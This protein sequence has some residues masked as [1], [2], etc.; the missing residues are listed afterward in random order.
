GRQPVPAAADDHDVVAG[1]RVGMAPQP[2]G[3]L[4]EMWADGTHRAKGSAGEFR[5][6][7]TLARAVRAS[8]LTRDTFGRTRHRDP[9]DAFQQR[10]R[11]DDG[12]T[13]TM[14]RPTREGG[15]TTPTLSV[16]SLWK[17]FGP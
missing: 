10:K 8:T 7:A 14:E 11:G 16:R 1:L 3:V 13:A 6:V 15:P 9:T 17:V 5:C 2:I 4:G 12:V